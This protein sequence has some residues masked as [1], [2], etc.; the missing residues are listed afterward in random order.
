MTTSSTRANGECAVGYPPIE[1]TAVG[2]PVEM[3]RH[4]LSPTNP[5]AVSNQNSQNNLMMNSIQP[6]TKCHFKRYRNYD[7][8]LKK[9]DG[10]GKR[11]SDSAED[12][13]RLQ[14]QQM[15]LPE[16]LD[17]CHT[18]LFLGLSIQ[19]NKDSSTKGDPANAN[20]KLRPNKIRE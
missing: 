3:A 10:Y 14:T 8:A 5:F 1:V 20:R 2:S 12:Q 13:L 7:G 16:F 19:K 18:Y 11:N 17:A 15:T 9:N 4:W 6:H